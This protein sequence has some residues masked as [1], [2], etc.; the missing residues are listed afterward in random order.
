MKSN[1]ILALV[2][3]CILAAWPV[4][5]WSLD[6]PAWSGFTSGVSPQTIVFT[7]HGT[8]TVSNLVGMASGYPR[9]FGYTSL[10]H[11]P[12]PFTNTLPALWPKGPSNFSWTI[13]F[14]PPLTPADYIIIADV[15]NDE[16]AT[17]RAYDSNDQPVAVTGW[18]QTLVDP[19]LPDLG[20]QGSVTRSGNEISFT[21]VSIETSE[22]MA[23]FQIAPGQ[24]VARLDYSYTNTPI[25]GGPTIAFATSDCGCCPALQIQRRPTDLLLMW[26]ATGSNC[27]LQTTVTLAPVNWTNWPSAPTL[28]GAILEQAILPDTTTRF[29][30]LKRP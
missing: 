4:D 8:L 10:D 22:E 26:S 7:N 3:V 25:S 28:N 18:S 2:R 21:G 17:V 13:S 1:R 11:I 19:M 30:R 9:Y 29:F 23:I 27:V 14:A 5:G 20:F 6:Y 16:R 12:A 15:D 24:T